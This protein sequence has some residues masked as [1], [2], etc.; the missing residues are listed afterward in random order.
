MENVIFIKWKL[1]VLLGP[2]RSGT[3]FDSKTRLTFIKP[4]KI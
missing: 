3:E 1:G 4:S 2:Y